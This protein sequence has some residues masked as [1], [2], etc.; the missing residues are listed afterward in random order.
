MMT[1]EPGVDQ[2]RPTVDLPLGQKAY[3]CCKSASSMNATNRITADAR[4]AIHSKVKR[5]DTFTETGT[6]KERHDERTKTAIDVKANVIRLGQ[7]CE[8]RNRVLLSAADR[9]HVRS[10]HRESWA[11]NQQA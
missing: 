9:Q 2:T 8:F 3:L 10:R 11:Q 7:L 5:L 1:D 4:H 6:M